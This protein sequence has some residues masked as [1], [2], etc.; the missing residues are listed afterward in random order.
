[1]EEYNN[2]TEEYQEK[3]GF[4][5]VGNFAMT[6]FVLFVIYFFFW[7]TGQ[8]GSL[9]YALIGVA[10]V[11]ISIF[12]YICISSSLLP[13]N[14]RIIKKLGKAGYECDM[15]EGMIYFIKSDCKWWIHTA[16]ISKHYR[17]VAFELAFNADYLDKDHASA[18]RMVCIVG[19][20]NPAV[21]TTWNGKDA[22]R[23]IFHTVL[24]SS[25]DIAREF[26]N[27]T[28]AINTAASEFFYLKEKFFDEGQAG[29]EHKVG[30]QFGEKTE[31]ETEV[32]ETRA[33][34]EMEIK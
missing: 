21:I 6:L 11:A 12:G 22:V 32:Q 27:A 20:R 13:T 34:K 4:A 7:L 19:H 25:K 23:F 28:D 31:V 14:E 8:T 29:D 9:S 10:V 30:F 5:S 2:E 3:D 18:N 1:M 15:E 24:T 33:R 26:T 16:N 17:K